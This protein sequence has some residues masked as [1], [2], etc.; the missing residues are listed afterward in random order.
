MPF[1]RN[2][3]AKIGIFGQNSN[4]EKA[5]FDELTQI[6]DELTPAKFIFWEILCLFTFLL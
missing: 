2:G 1:L 3:M 6:K 4:T 5:L